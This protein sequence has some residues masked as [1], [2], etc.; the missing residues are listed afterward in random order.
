M[1]IVMEHFLMDLEKEKQDIL[2]LKKKIREKIMVD[3]AIA[4]EY[5]KDIKESIEVLEKKLNNSRYDTAKK[6]VYEG[7]EFFRQ[8]SWK[9]LAKGIIIIG[10]LPALDMLYQSFS[11][12]YKPIDTRFYEVYFSSNMELIGGATLYFSHNSTKSHKDSWEN[13]FG[14]GTLTKNNLEALEEIVGKCKKEY[15]LD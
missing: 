8:D 5:E 9:N 3:K 1:P 14:K 13:M 7:K 15:I 10:A 4:N 2:S 6:M 11:G 12:N